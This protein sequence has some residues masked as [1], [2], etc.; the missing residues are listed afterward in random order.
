MNR[1][2]VFTSALVTTTLT[3]VSLLLV[4]RSA[5]AQSGASTPARAEAR[6]AAGTPSQASGQG[7][8]TAG[9]M[10]LGAN[11]SLGGRRAMAGDSA[12]N[13]PIDHLPADSA[14]D[15][16]INTIG[17]D[18]SLH[19]DFGTTYAGAP[20]GI[21]YVIVPAETPRFPV[22]FDYADESD[23]VLY[24]IPP[25]APIE[26]VAPGKMPSGDGDHHILMIDRDNA[27][28]FELY[29]VRFKDGRWHAGSGAVW[30]LF[31]DTKRERGWTSADAAG[32]AIFPGLVRYEEM[33]ELGRIEHA[34][35]FTVPK[36][37]R[38]YV[39]PATHAASRDSNSSLPPM[40]M[41]VRLKASVDVNAFPQHVRPLLVALK[42]YG[43]I[44]A[45]NGGPFY[46]SGAPD[47]RWNDADIDTLKR[48]K[49][50]D[51]EVVQMGAVIEP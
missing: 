38:A 10:A 13:I 16:I 41:R 28:L 48:I 35:R 40:G 25:D 26:G 7:S 33:V 32:L 45:D 21:P 2:V 24:P 3:I 4:Q 27:R 20:W 18:I 8:A 46:V 22:V 44:L 37:R 42:K 9:T 17:A 50:R 1:H 34:L 31:G 5:I 29:G 11:A 39:A 51:F 43:M 19:P 49:G 23:D 47:P 6:T 12:W 36:S 15:K 30:D 14:S